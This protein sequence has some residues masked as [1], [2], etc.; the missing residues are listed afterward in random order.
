MHSIVKH[1][2]VLVRDNPEQLAPAHAW[3]TLL[4]NCSITATRSHDTC[5]MQHSFDLLTHAIPKEAA[6]FFTQGIQEMEKS[7]YPQPVRD[8]MQHYFDRYSRPKMN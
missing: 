3:R 7:S 2:D 6:S 5:L 1:C 4:F 8:V